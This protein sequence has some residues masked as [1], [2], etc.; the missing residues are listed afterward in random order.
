MNVSGDQSGEE[1][2][3]VCGVPNESQLVYGDDGL[4]KRPFALPPPNKK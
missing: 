3:E 4:G 2:V 1:E